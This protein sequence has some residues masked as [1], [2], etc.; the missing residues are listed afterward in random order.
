VATMAATTSTL[1]D[2][3]TTAKGGA[4]GGIRLSA[5][6]GWSHAS[7]RRDRNRAQVRP[8]GSIG[9]IKT[10]LAFAPVHGRT[11]LRRAYRRVVLT[12]CRS[13]AV[14][15]GWGAGRRS[16]GPRA[17]LLLGDGCVTCAP[18]FQVLALSEQ[19]PRHPLP[20]DR[21]GRQV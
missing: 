4:W 2:R 5:S 10:F 14:R 17:G 8:K 20:E 3:R 21:V 1:A 13:A 9:E 15:R 12:R 7:P 18:G 11:D 19:Q 6:R 16:R